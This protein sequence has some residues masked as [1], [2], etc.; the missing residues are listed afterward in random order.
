MDEKPAREMFRTMRCSHPPMFCSEC[1]CKYI[2]TKVIEGNIFPVKCPDVRCKVVLEPHFCRSVVPKEVLDR[3][4]NTFDCPFEDCCAV[5]VV[6]K[7][8]SKFKCYACH[9]LLCAQCKVSWH[10]GTECTEHIRKLNKENDIRL[11][12][13]ACT[14]KWRR[15]PRCYIYVERT[16]GCRYITCRLITI[17]FCA[18]V[19]SAMN[20]DVRGARAM[21]TLQVV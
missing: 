2:A 21:M 17:Y 7:V 12:R 9:R 13:L 19:D 18:G 10:G 4:S 1:I 8:V 16:H 14:M 5:L 3:W 11:L 15:C 6:D 20:A